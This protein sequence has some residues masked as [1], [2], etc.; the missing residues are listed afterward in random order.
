MAYRIEPATT[1]HLPWLR[2]LFTRWVAEH[3]SDYPTMDEEEFDAFVIN[4]A[5]HLTVNREAAVFVAIKGHRVVGFIGL[6]ITERA[7]GKPRRTGTVHYLYVIPKHRHRLCAAQLITV[8]MDWLKSH[9]VAVIE[10][11]EQRSQAGA[12]IRRKFK[13]YMV[14]YYAPIDQVFANMPRMFRRGDDLPTTLK[15]SA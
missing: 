1:A 14:K 6:E 9:D 3:P 5:R 7:V 10:F 8:G 15:E 4:L 2:L 13:A 11:G 12:W